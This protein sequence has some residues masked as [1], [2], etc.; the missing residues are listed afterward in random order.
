[1]E[2]KQ[3]KII[4]K[5]SEQYGKRHEIYDY[6]ILCSN[7]SVIYDALNDSIENMFD[8]EK[9]YGTLC[10]AKK[11]VVISYV[12]ITNNGYFLRKIITPEQAFGIEEQQ[13]KEEEEFNALFESEDDEEI[14]KIL[15][16]DLW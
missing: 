6:E 16:D 14:D 3:V 2:N 12:T 1:M 4:F 13:I 5:T 10:T 11:E 15:S 7:L 8:G 9:I